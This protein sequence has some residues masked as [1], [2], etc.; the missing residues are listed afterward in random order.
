[1]ALAA[2]VALLLAVDHALDT[3]VGSFVLVD[4]LAILALA[5]LLDLLRRAGDP[6]SVRAGLVGGIV[7]LAARLALPPVA[8]GAGALDVGLVLGAAFL[9]ATAFAALGP[10][11]AGRTVL[12]TVSI[13][14]SLLLLLQIRL[15][16]SPEHP[17]AGLG[18]VA[19]VIAVVKGGDAA[20]YFV[21]R[22]IGRRPMAPRISPKKT[23]EGAIAGFVTG[24][25]LAVALGWG[26]GLMPGLGLGTVLI[27]GA[28]T[29]VA[30]QAGDLIESAV[31][32]RAGAKDSGRYLGEMGGA[33]DVL[34]ALLVAGPVAY[35]AIRLLAPWGG[36]DR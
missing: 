11:G 4:V 1:M 9:L 32:R 29:N 15:F 24:T 35:T 36:V 2:G 21:G 23:W 22:T 13:V 18:A 30:G 5:E 16:G 27:I 8:P 25:A 31:K 14:G 26:G 10:R 19:V 17:R 12:A 20:A 7:L 28:V 34:D 3:P 33:L 6:V